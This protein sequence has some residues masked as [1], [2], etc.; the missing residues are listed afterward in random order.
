[1]LLMF[2]GERNR[3]SIMDTISLR[4]TIKLIRESIFTVQ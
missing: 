1:M 2:W 3:H 4:V